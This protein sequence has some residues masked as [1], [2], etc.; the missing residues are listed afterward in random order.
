LWNAQSAIIKTTSEEIF[1]KHGFAPKRMMKRNLSKFS[2][3]LITAILIA[4][5][6]SSLVWAAETAKPESGRARRPSGGGL[7]PPANG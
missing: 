1:M 2:V 6:A 4:G 5:T 3:L 7:D